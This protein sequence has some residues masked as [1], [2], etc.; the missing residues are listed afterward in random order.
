[1]FVPLKVIYPAADV[2]LVQLSLETSRDPGR[3]LAIGR[4]LA[5]LRDEG[6]LIVGS[7]MSYHNLREFF[8]DRPGSNHAAEDFD[9]WLNDILTNKDPEARAEGL[10][11][12]RSATSTSAS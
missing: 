9:A 2:P 10:A 12:W 7:G 8:A 3:H 11:V 6:V 1:M 4:A 5:P